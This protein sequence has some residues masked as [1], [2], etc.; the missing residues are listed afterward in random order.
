M[1]AQHTGLSDASSAQ[2]GSRSAE[3][4]NRFLFIPVISTFGFS[5]L[6]ALLFAVFAP[7]V[8]PFIVWSLI[9]L[10][11]SFSFIIYY[12]TK[13]AFLRVNTQAY[14]DIT[15]TQNK[16][17]RLK[18]RLNELK[19]EIDVLKRALRS[20]ASNTKIG[21]VFRR[22]G[23]ELNTPSSYML[24][25]MHSLKRHVFFLEQLTQYFITLMSELSK[26]E[27]LCHEPTIHDIEK[28]L[29]VEDLDFVISDAYAVI[30][31]VI[32]GV[33]QVQAFTTSLTQLID[34]RSLPDRINVNDL[35]NQTTS[36]INHDLK[37]HIEV[38]LHL[39]SCPD[40]H[41]SPYA[42]SHVL[43]NILMNATQAIDSSGGKITIMTFR[44]EE[45]VVIEIADTG[46]GIDEQRLKKVSEPFYSHPKE[47]GFA[48]LGLSISE[49]ALT[50][51]G[52]ELH[53]QS[54]VGTGTT[55]QLVIPEYK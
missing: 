1:A 6:V 34:E 10:S 55:V 53:I 22:S 46:S 25:N 49:E 14:T 28:T 30:E 44:N 41:M 11:A 3:R 15:T 45:N 17:Q 32:T 4:A 36:V 12:F 16:Y 50:E 39:N 7:E 31:E 5:V 29:K 8:T 18:T 40:V 19:R 38:E 48:G 21:E 2:Q 54:Q 9:G 52:G 42:L 47:R 26:H 43:L 13:R 20:Q 27:R 35:V 51:A 24:N 23:Y 33:G 37:P